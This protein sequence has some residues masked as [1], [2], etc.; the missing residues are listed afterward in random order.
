MNDDWKK[1]WTAVLQFAFGAVLSVAAF[2]LYV[3]NVRCPMET[4]SIVEIA[5]ELLLF[6]STF[7]FALAASRTPADAGALYL[8]AGFTSVCFIR[9]LDACLDQLFHGAWKYLEFFYVF[10]LYWVL[11][12]NDFRT[13]IPG[14]ARYSRSR[15]FMMLLPGLVVIFAYSRLFGMRKLWNLYMPSHSA[16]GSVKTFAEESVELLGYAIV[17]GASLIAAH[18]RPGRRA[19]GRR[20]RPPRRDPMAGRTA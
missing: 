2:S 17:F 16:L 4:E 18:Q 12:K 10:F 5:Q 15:S 19:H 6:L 20:G 9:E 14:L 13:I 3:L 8:I 11:R 1:I 7:F